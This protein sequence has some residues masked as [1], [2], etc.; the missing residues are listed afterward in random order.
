MAEQKGKGQGKKEVYKVKCSL[1][2]VP[3]SFEHLIPVACA[4]Q[5]AVYPRTASDRCSELRSAAV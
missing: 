2:H 5:V 4:E 1:N 3:L